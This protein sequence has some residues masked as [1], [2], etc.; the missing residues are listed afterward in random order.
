M[1]RPV[2]KELNVQRIKAYNGLKFYRLIYIQGIPT[3]HDFKICGPRYFRI[4]FQATN[5]VNSLPFRDFHKKRQTFSLKNLRAFFSDDF[6]SVQ[7]SYMCWIKIK[8][9]LDGP[10]NSWFPHF[11]ITIQYQKSWNAGTS[12]IT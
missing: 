5:F 4:L 11:R 3:F 1:S 12:C 10:R 2:R 8:S 7:N 6:F 9:Y